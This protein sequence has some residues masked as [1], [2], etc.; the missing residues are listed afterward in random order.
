VVVE[1]EG[2]DPGAVVGDGLLETVPGGAGLDLV[3]LVAEEAVVGELALLGLE[4]AGGKRAGGEE[5]VRANGD[6]AGDR[7]LLRV[8]GFR[9]P[10]SR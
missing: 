3:D 7:A 9:E 10:N 1:H 5:G 2:E 8:S 6:E 4:P